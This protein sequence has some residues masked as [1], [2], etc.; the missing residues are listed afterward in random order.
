MSRTALITGAG[1]GIGAATAR[2]L[3]RRGFHTIVNY[4]R[5]ADSAAAVVKDIEA[6]GGTARAV[7]ADVCDP[8]QVD[9]L[10]D[11]CP[12]LDALVCNANQQP[13]FGPL[14]SMT[15][16]MFHGKLHGELAAAFHVSRHALAQMRERRAGT[17]VYVSSVSAALTSPGAIAH[18]SAKA[19][20][21]AF[22][23]HVAL[24]AAPHGITVNTIAPAAVA[25]EA[26]AAVLTPERRAAI[27][28]RSVLGRVLEPED[29]ARAIAAAVEGGLD[30]GGLQAVTGARIAVDGGYLLM[31][32]SS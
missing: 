28:G 3:A 12:P 11:A 22:A 7:R 19:A 4:V 18:S 8:V 16:E 1:R 24:E 13:P 31:A 15:W 6:A 29:V 2:E 23:R 10:L 17:I 25:T 27:A 30:R 20:L 21:E 14:E 9:A 26:T 5:D 32:D